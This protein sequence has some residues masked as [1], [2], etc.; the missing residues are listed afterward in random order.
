MDKGGRG[1][2]QPHTG[3]SMDELQTLY[4]YSMITEMCVGVC[5]S[6]Y[7]YLERSW[8]TPSVE[9][10]VDSPDSSHWYLLL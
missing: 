6:S 9:Y 1:V 8:Q 3:Y 10:H 5:P 2:P 7:L 4:V